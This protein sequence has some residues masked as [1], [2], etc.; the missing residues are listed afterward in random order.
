VKQP[1]PEFIPETESALR[2]IVTRFGRVDA[3]SRAPS[4]TSIKT[5]ETLLGTPLPSTWR[6]FVSKVN[7]GSPARNHWIG[8]QERVP[9]VLEFSYLYGV[10]VANPHLDAT[11]WVLFFGPSLPE[12]YV[13]IGVFAGRWEDQLLLKCS[14]G[15]RQRVYRWIWHPLRKVPLPPMLLSESLSQFLGGLTRSLDKCDM[16]IRTGHQPEMH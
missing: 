11:S 14:A 15:A 16:A 4:R 3:V 10:G 9:V 1:P 8:T 6:R 13:P 7:G 12:G 5:L 2:S